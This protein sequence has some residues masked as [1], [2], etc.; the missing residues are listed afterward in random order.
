M[1]V[2]SVVIGFKKIVILEF[3]QLVEI[4]R[5]ANKRAQQAIEANSRFGILDRIQVEQKK[6]TVLCYY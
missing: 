5:L 1:V 3:M 2:P 4:Q 6:V